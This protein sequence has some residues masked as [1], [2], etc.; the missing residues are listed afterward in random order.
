MNLEPSHNIAQP[1]SSSYNAGMDDRRSVG[2][3]QEYRGRLLARQRF[4]AAERNLSPFYEGYLGRFDLALS[5][6]TATTRRTYLDAARRFLYFLEADMGLEALPLESISREHAREWLRALQSEGAAAATV[7]IL[8]TGARRFFAVM[9]ED[10]EV[11]TNPFEGL[12]TPDI[13]LKEP[14]ILTPEEVQA[15]LDAA[16]RE[17]TLWGLRDRAIIFC[18]YDGGFRRA[19]L[20]NLR[21]EDIDLKAGTVL[22]TAGKGNRQRWVPLSPNAFRALMQYVTA[23]RKWV[24]SRPWYRQEALQETNLWLSRHG[25]SLGI[26]G[27]TNLL[28]QRAREA[29]VKK[30]V[31][32]HA[33]RH[34]SATYQARQ[35]IPEAE[36]EAKMGWAPGSRQVHRY[37]RTSLVERAIEGHRRYGPA[38]GLKL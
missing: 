5:D 13:K 29:G 32:P 36:L 17:R 14:T 33:F 6:V 37:T 34:S 28:R 9:Q 16:K 3:P 11:P 12:R 7:R 27:L 2:T 23:R 18:L 19:E 15:M 25:D 1:R 22:V 26:G 8:Y 21:E 10:G 38:A 30:R 31:H 20:L 35:H 24:A 4:V